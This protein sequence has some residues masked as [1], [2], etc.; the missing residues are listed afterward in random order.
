MLLIMIYASVLRST[1]HVKSPM[2]AGI[3]AVVLNTILNYLL[4]FGKFGFPE[5]GFLGTAYAT[6][7]TRFLEAGITYSL[8]LC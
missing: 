4:I 2:Y 3:V 8:Y 1:G 6:T 5:I 7:I